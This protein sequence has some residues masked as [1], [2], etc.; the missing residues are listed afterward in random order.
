MLTAAPPSLCV[1]IVVYSTLW[2]FLCGLAMYLVPALGFGLNVEFTGPRHD[3]YVEI[4]TMLVQGEGFRFEPG[5][6]PVMHRPPLY[7]VLLMPFVGLPAA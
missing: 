7:P 4:A 6:P 5:G 3:G 1:R 2:V